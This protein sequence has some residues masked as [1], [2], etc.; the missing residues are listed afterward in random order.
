[1]VSDRDGGKGK[2]SRLSKAAGAA[3]DSVAGEVVVPSIALR[4]TSSKS[5]AR[6][7]L[8]CHVQSP[9]VPCAIV[10][11]VNGGS[12]RNSTYLDEKGKSCMGLQRSRISGCC[13][14][15]VQARW[16]VH[17]QRYTAKA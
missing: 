12:T 17:V 16:E 8:S 13:A 10:K 6:C 5:D 1:M 9:S 2:G 7:T 4:R 14:T 3:A 15:H 11:I